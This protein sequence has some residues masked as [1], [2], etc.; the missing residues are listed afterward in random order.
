MHRTVPNALTQSLRLPCLG[1][2]AL[3]AVFLLSMGGAPNTVAEAQSAT[4]LRDYR[5]QHRVLIIVS[6]G[7]LADS[8]SDSSG[9]SGSASP[10]LA[11]DS[12]P[13][14]KQLAQQA[15]AIDE[16]DL[17]WFWLCDHGY[18]SNIDAELAPAFLEELREAGRGESGV[19]IIGKDGGVKYRASYLDLQQIFDTIDSMPMRAREMREREERG[20][21]KSET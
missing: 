3:A 1:F 4:S 19:N 10:P 8:C 7:F 16:R 12:D 14:I 18:Y 5:W 9:K 6:D 17:V 21:G 2:A 20:E 13:Q 15:A 11:D